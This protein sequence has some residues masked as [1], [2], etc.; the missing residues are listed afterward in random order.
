MKG[1]DELQNQD[2]I[3]SANIHKE[4]R[5]TKSFFTKQV[6]NDLIPNNLIPRQW[7][8]FSSKNKSL[9]CFCCLLF[10]KENSSISRFTKQGGFQKWK[11]SENISEHEASQSHQDPLNVWK[12]QKDPTF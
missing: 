4:R 5:L 3:E 2:K 8:L 7:L 9:N 12:I 10:G 1:P 6:G 11:K